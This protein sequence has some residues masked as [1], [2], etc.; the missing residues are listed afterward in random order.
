[1]TTV[2]ER[3]AAMR[4]AYGDRW[5]GLSK[6][7]R[8][9]A[10]QS[11]DAS[12][13]PLAASSAAAAPA[14]PRSSGPSAAA[15]RTAAA[16]AAVGAHG[17][18]TISSLEEILPYVDGDTLVYLEVDSTL[19]RP[20]NH[21]CSDDWSS[22]LRHE[23]E[24]ESDVAHGAVER[25]AYWMWSALQHGVQ[26]ETCEGAAT[27]AALERVERA[28]RDVVVLT[29]RHPSLFRETRAALSEHSLLPTPADAGCVPEGGPRINTS[30]RRRVPVDLSAGA[31][32]DW[33]S[34]G[35]P[36]S[37]TGAA[38]PPDMASPIVLSRR[39]I[40]CAGDRKGAGSQLYLDFFEDC[41]RRAR[42]LRGRGRTYITPLV[43]RKQLVRDPF[44]TVI[45]TVVVVDTNATRLDDV[46]RSIRGRRDARSVNFVGF[47]YDRGAS[48]GGDGLD[49]TSRA[50]VAAL[51][52][53]SARDDLRCLLGVLDLQETLS[54]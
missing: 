1:M 19:L 7:E 3:L 27:C 13:V 20:A 44:D 17:Y 23:L 39:V 6:A 48:S 10:L 47:Y 5:H 11:G 24:A 37:R 52:H 28:A 15:L 29:A 54:T 36:K 30:E 18:R 35:D 2:L 34:L 49:E 22:A 4:S 43:F 33:V 40:Y 50:L 21:C 9:D 25:V 53:K 42:D 14:L 45:K 8:L 38:L 41:N 51:Q 12:S 26:T 31:K 32:G 46:A 16:I